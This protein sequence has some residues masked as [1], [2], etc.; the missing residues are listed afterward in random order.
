M[1]KRFIISKIFSSAAFLFLSFSMYAQYYNTGQDPASL[2]WMQVKTGRFNVIYPENYGQSGP[3]FAQALEEA[4]SDISLLYPEKKFRIP[5]I[6]HNYTTQSN[7]FVAWAPRRMELYP[8]PDQNSIPLDIK[9]QLVLHELTHV[10]QMES[11]NSGFSRVMSYIA[12]EQFPGAIA[13]LLPSWLMEGEAVFAET[14]LSASGRGRSP[15]FHNSLKA[16]AIEND[17]LFKYDKLLNGS[18]RDF[19]PDYYQYGYQMF[20]WSVLNTDM[21]M[22]NRILDFA[23]NQPFTLNPVNISLRRNTGLTKKQLYYQTFDSLKNL[24]DKDIRLSGAIDYSAVNP[25]KK[26]SFESYHSAVVAGKDSIIAVKTS[27]GNPLRFVLIR[28]SEKSEKKL[29]APGNLYPWVISYAQGIIVWVESV[30][31]PRWENRNYSVIKTYDLKTA[32]PHQVTF[33]SRYLAASIS[34]DGKLIAASENTVNNIN[35]LVLINPSD[36]AVTGCYPAPE[37]A[38]LQRPQWSQDGNIITVISLT[39]E[40][41]GILSFSVAEKIWKTLVHE[42]SEDLQA[43][44][45]RNDTLYYVSSASGTDNVF[46]ITPDSVK[47]MLTNSKFGATDPFV[48]GDKVYFSNYS[49]SGNNICSVPVSAAFRPETSGIYRASFLIDRFGSEKTEVQKKTTVYS[50]EPYKKWKHLFNIHSWMPVYVDIEQV[51]SDLASIR[52]GFTIMSQSHLSTLTAS[53]GYE[54]AA[55]GRH[56]FH[57][58]ITWEGWYPVLESRFDYGNE[59]VISLFGETPVWLPSPARTGFRFYNNIHIPWRFSTGKFYQYLYPFLVIDYH[60]DYMYSRETSTYDY[61]QTQLTG[62]IYFANYQKSSYRDIYPKFGQVVDAAYEFA[63]F[64]RSFCGSDI[65]LKSIFYFPGVLRNH[66]IRIRYEAENQEFVKFLTSNNIRYPRGYKDIISKGL[67]LI[68]FDYSAPLV[69]PDFNISSILYIKRIRGGLF[70]DYARGTD[71]Y[72]LIRDGGNRIIDHSVKGKE[73]FRSYGIELLS[74]FYLLRIPYPV[75]AGVQA[76]WKN[77]SEPPVVEF[78]FNID[79]YGMNIGKMSL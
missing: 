65:S 76:A 27:L 72:Y 71:N 73:T 14:I 17:R 61:G 41:E 11:L 40:G 42:E 75:S 30:P 15:S 58:R 3:E 29:F 35:N 12:G 23:A 5:V 79:I 16:I 66:G 25:V 55:D 21:H 53:A 26:T 57:T 44:F 69:Y 24:W 49:A 64:D 34:P 43:S 45:V 33:R 56:K 4:Y 32:L 7:G 68:S 59:P 10:M 50:P 48:S 20:A 70:Y 1:I 52:P 6:I 54:Y 13:A 36:G 46:I 38:S 39:E 22:W 28:P 51:Q 60:N 31:D 19:T 9:R 18:Y 67:D 74:D 62:R 77:I 2:K 37:N 8:T 63:P 47:L 78:I